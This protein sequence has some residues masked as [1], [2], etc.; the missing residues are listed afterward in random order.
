M[1]PFQSGRLRW[2][3]HQILLYS[4]WFDALVNEKN[5]KASR[6]PNP[7]YKSLSNEPETCQTIWLPLH[8][9][10]IPLPVITLLAPSRDLGILRPVLWPTRDS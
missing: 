9:R 6:D 7:R 2:I 3:F 8:S 5:F 4:L 1:M 10:T